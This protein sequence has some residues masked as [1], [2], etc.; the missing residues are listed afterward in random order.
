MFD[1]V[2]FM[3][4]WRGHRSEYS[5]I[6]IVAGV[7]NAA[8]NKSCVLLAAEMDNRQDSGNIKWWKRVGP[9]MHKRCAKGEMSANQKGN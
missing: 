8:L 3:G 1:P 2:S 6:I 5:G 7:A 9:K 4:L